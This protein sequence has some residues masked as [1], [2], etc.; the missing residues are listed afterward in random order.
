MELIISEIGVFAEF[1]SVELF[2]APRTRMRIPESN[3]PPP[4]A[5]E[6]PRARNK[7]R[8]WLNGYFLARECNVA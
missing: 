3:S 4:P 2:P 7:K 1:R 8:R 5:A 6:I